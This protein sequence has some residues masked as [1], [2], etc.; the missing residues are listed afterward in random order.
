MVKF[1]V[2]LLGG[3][4]GSA[5]AAC[6]GC[7]T[8]EPSPTLANGACV[9]TVYNCKVW[10]RYVCDTTRLVN[11]SNCS[12][13]FLTKSGTWSIYNSNGVALGSFT[14]GT[15]KVKINYGIQAVGTNLDMVLCFAKS[16]DTGTY[17]GW[18]DAQAV[19]ESMTG[20]NNNQPGDPGGTVSLWYTK[21]SDN[22]PYLDAD[23]DAFKV[24]GSS[25]CGTTGQ[26]ATDYLTR[27]PGNRNNMVYNLP[28]NGY[29]SPTEGV[30]TATNKYN[31]Y[32]YTNVASVDRSLYDCEADD[33]SSKKLTF[34]F[35]RQYEKHIARDGSTVIMSRRGWTPIDCL[36]AGTGLSD[37]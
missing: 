8:L 11:R 34:L 2:V 17:S 23:G 18:L 24:T 37:Y 10:P 19:A 21:I 7:T 15:A 22:T 6:S 12:E 4:G 5:W 26:Q 35:G 14:G 9:N 25:A 32:R 31:F 33:Y 20:N 1:L 13:S 30:R 27:Q 16:T 28:G 29:G 3:L 36:T